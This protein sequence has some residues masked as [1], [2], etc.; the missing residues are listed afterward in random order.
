MR[1]SMRN[2]PGDLGELPEDF[3][4]KVGVN[5]FLAIVPDLSP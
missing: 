5:G 3:K 2:N 1:P 4:R